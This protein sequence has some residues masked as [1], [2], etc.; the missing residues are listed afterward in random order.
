M[1]LICHSNALEKWIK[2]IE[3]GS[4]QS[5]QWILSQVIPLKCGCER[6]GKYPY[7][8]STD[9][10]RFPDK[11]FFMVGNDQRELN[12][13][14]RMDD[15]IIRTSNLLIVPLTNHHYEPI[16]CSNRRRIFIF[17]IQIWSHAFF[18]WFW[19]CTYYSCKSLI[20]SFR[21]NQLEECLLHSRS[22]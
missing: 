14:N 12:L 2:N 1:L 21:S 19:R 3:L 7:T 16:H 20:Q 22:H 5:H 6:F 9:L 17:T 11:I 15:L 18:I 4:F 10:K 13:A 8:A